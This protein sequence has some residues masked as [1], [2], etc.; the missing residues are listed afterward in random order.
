MGTECCGWRGESCLSLSS[1]YQIW[2]LLHRSLKASRDWRK[3]NVWSKRLWFCIHKP[4]QEFTLHFK[5]PNK[6]LFLLAFL[7]PF[8]I[9]TNRNAFIFLSEGVREHFLTLNSERRGSFM[10]AFWFRQVVSSRVTMPCGNL[11]DKQGSGCAGV[12][13]SGRVTECAWERWQLRGVL[14]DVRIRDVLK[15]LTD[16]SES[17]RIFLDEP[18]SPGF[19]FGERL[20]SVVVT[21]VAGFQ[22]CA[23][24]CWQGK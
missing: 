11:W 24:L 5:Q 23:C 6:I 13:R 14:G 4:C 2:Q 18:F 19:L 16:I 7:G 17:A 10:L 15:H 8:K 21:A 22:L 1:F 20:V 12:Q 9:K 3:I